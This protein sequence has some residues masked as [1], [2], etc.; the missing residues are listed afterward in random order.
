MRKIVSLYVK[1]GD[2]DAGFY[3]R[4]KQ[5]FREMDI[6]VR[7]HKMYSDWVYRNLLPVST[8]PLI[9][10]VLL[11]V[12]SAGRV[13]AQLISDFFCTPNTVVVS[14][15]LVSRWMP[16]GCGYIL[17]S[18]YQKGT[19]IIW[20]FDDNIVESKECDKRAFELFARLSKNIIIASPVLKNLIP[21][22]FHNKIINL[23]STDGELYS[24]VTE[25]VEKER[26]V[27]FQKEVRIIWLGTQVS[28]NYVEDVFSQI[29]AAGKEI[30]KTGRKIVFTV[31]CDKEP[32][33]ES[34]IVDVRYVKWSREKAFAELKTSHIGI[35]P[36]A[37]NKFTKGKGGF[38][39][40]QY[41][42]IGLPVIATGVGINNE[43]VDTNI[44]FLAENLNDD[45]WQKAIIKLSSDQ[46]V[47]KEFSTAARLKYKESYSFEYNL[48]V[49]KKLLNVED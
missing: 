22:I 5:Y 45:V 46:G 43:I 44:G 1:G 11:W 15:R 28:L 7:V 21:T 8:K 49:W 17:N 13:Y 37:V 20:D 36:L 29:E 38:K 32:N 48:E 9:I 41:I 25:E 24:L 33:V 3:Y 10:Q 40:I 6:D 34:E 42:S 4:Y 12:Y 23:P 31:V 16:F 26:L 47:W 30:K 19:T 39:L 27:L 18:L 35:M 2:I 14:R